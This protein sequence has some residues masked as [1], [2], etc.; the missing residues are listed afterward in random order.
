ALGKIGQHLRVICPGTPAAV[1]D[2][3]KDLCPRPKK[4]PG[5]RNPAPGSLESSHAG[6]SDDEAAG[7]EDTDAGTV[8]VDTGGSVIATRISLPRI[9][10]QHSFSAVIIKDHAGPAEPCP[11]AGAQP[12]IE[13]SDG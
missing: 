5:C 1:H 11:S 10:H 8:V 4:Q 7:I 6:G 13:D 2:R 9:P 3:I 12:A